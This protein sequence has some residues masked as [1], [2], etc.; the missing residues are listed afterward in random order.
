MDNI[1]IYN[2]YNRIQQIYHKISNVQN[3]IEKKFINFI[4]NQ[5]NPETIEKNE[6]KNTQNK[7]NTKEIPTKLSKDK[8]INLINTI[9]EEEGVSPE[10]IKA[11]VKVESN[12]KTDA[13]SPKG[14][15]GLMQL[16]PATA[17]ILD[18]DYKDP[19]ENLRGGIQ[20]LKDL[21]LKYKNLDLVLS[22]YNA[23]PGNVDKYN[24][25]PPFAE[26]KNYINKIKKI[27]NQFEE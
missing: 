22:A 8:I 2:V 9:A 14:A 1:G 21:A 19:Q 23:G 3:S 24:G 26:T 27:L 25:I 15:Y 7:D 4:Q 5:S 17:K 20:Y 18:V 13:K 16:L 11:I 6:I 10:L 12:F